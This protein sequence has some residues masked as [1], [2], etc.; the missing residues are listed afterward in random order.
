MNLKILGDTKGLMLMDFTCVLSA[1][2][3]RLSRERVLL[4][5]RAPRVRYRISYLDDNNHSLSFP[6]VLIIMRVI[7]ATKSQDVPLAAV[8]GK[9][10]LVYWNILG[11]VQPIRLVLAQAGADCVDVRIEGGNADHADYKQNWVKA[12]ENLSTVLNF[13]NLP[14]ML[15]TNGVNLSQ[16]DTI[17]KY[18]ARKFDLMGVPGKEYVV[19]LALDELKDLEGAMTR[20]A[21]TKG[22]D[23]VA[24]WFEKSGPKI[25]QTFT[26]LLQTHDFLTGDRVSVADFKL[27]SFLSKLRIVQNELSQVIVLNEALNNFMKRIEELPSIKAYMASPNYQQRPI[28]NPEAKWR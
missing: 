28:N 18:L 7:V 2:K 13:P 17:L 15:D 20:C 16:T 23:A 22:A 9:L 8:D 21:Y 3:S 25:V 14:Y 26:G 10:T 4:Y 27:Y 11:L 1:T 12:K 24:A 5:R 6:A 19:D